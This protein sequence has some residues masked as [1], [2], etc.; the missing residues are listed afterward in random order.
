M[1]AAAPGKTAAA[2][3]VVALAKKTEWCQLQ[4]PFTS[5][6]EFLGTFLP[7]KC[8]GAVLQRQIGFN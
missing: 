8:D 5:S 3:V 2:A 7:T 1:P 4:I 6:S